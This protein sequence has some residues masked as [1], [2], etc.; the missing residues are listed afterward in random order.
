[1]HKYTCTLFIKY[2]KKKKHSASDPSCLRHFGK[3]A[4][5]YRLWIAVVNNITPITIKAS[6]V[7]IMSLGKYFF[8]L[9]FDFIIFFIALTMM[10]IVCVY[11]AL[12]NGYAPFGLCDTEFR[13]HKMGNAI[14]IAPMLCHG[15]N[16]Y[17]EIGGWKNTP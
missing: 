17:M 14:A 2:Q 6:L 8:F 10:F 13:S 4:R 11:F 15:C 3:L 12:W 9:N 7:K 5:H 1:M 16:F